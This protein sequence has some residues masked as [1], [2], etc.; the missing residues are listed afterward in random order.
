VVTKFRGLAG[1]KKLPASVL[2]AWEEG[3][4]AVL[5]DPAYR[6]EYARESLIPAYMGHEEAGR[7]TAR[8][9]AELAAS[10]RELGIA[11]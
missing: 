1:P 4:E 9:A 11:R 5:A 6:S 8:F 2:K 7:F 3:V 10:L